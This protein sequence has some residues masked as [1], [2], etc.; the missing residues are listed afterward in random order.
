MSV[1][2]SHPGGEHDESETHEKEIFEEA[3]QLYNSMTS[4][5]HWDAVRVH[6]NVTVEGRLRQYELDRIDE[7]F[8]EWDISDPNDQDEDDQDEDDEDEDDEDEDDEE[9]AIDDEATRE[10]ERRGKVDTWCDWAVVEIDKYRN[11][12]YTAA[13]LMATIEVAWDGVGE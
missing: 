13:E 8:G 6:G 11:G 2:F 3:L 12:E 7:Y 5:Q 4:K 9:M 10:A 1:L